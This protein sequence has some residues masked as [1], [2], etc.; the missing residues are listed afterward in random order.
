MGGSTVELDGL[1]RPVVE[2]AGLEFVEAVF[3]REQG[4]RILRVT[5]DR[6]GGVNLDAIAEVSERISR[7][8]DLEGFSS[9]PYSLEVSSPGIE[10]P[11]RE[12]RDFARR[13]GARVKVK[14]A[15]PDEGH[16]TLLGSIVEADDRQLKI[17]TD[18]GE[19]EL[20]YG[21]IA[22]ARTVLEWGGRT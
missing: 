1:I 14:T 17:A 18:E 13:V 15:R 3:D 2:G 16:R 12:P 10:R 9:G 19:V 20:A 11:L 22:S 21:D 4:R 6:V 7:R 5:V 8:L